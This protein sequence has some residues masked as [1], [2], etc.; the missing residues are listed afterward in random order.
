MGTTTTEITAVVL[1]PS[2]ISRGVDRGLLGGDPRGSNHHGSFI[3]IGMDQYEWD[4]EPP[5]KGLGVH[6]RYTSQDSDLV[7]L[8]SALRGSERVY[9]H[10]TPS[11]P[12]PN[13]GELI[14]FTDYQQWRRQ[15]SSHQPL[16][17]TNVGGDHRTRARYTYGTPWTT[18]TDGALWKPSTHRT[19]G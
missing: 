2:I 4:L 1:K 16:R 18:R 8:P 19:T 9:A 14:E 12:S 15:P 13:C 5:S 11:P 17:A 10:E 6:P 3:Q 7:Q